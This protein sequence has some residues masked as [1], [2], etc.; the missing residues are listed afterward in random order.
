M[1]HNVDD[2]CMI[3]LLHMLRV[4]QILYN[5]SASDKLDGR[6]WHCP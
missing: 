6:S 2:L 5:C 4:V 1:W 3:T